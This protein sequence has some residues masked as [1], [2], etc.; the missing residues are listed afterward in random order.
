MVVEHKHKV[1][2]SL[3]QN[4]Q[5]RRV[6]IK[7]LGSANILVDETFFYNSEGAERK[8]DYY[9]SKFSD[10]YE[11]LEAELGTDADQLFSELLA[12]SE[13]IHCG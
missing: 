7:G 4:F 6:P 8:M 9:C 12:K 3:A 5:S 11:L 1:L 2:I 10:L 13:F